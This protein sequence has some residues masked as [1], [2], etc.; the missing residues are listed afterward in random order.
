MYFTKCPY[1]GSN[2]DPGERCDCGGHKDKKENVKHKAASKK[3]ND[4]KKRK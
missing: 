2:N 4:L 1:C 3:K